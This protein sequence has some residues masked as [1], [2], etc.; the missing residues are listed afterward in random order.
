MDTDFSKHSFVL[1][2]ATGICAVWLLLRVSTGKGEKVVEEAYKVPDDD[3]ADDNVSRNTVQ[4]P[5]FPD[6]QS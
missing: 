6:D 2:I 1:Q 5:S 3:A 4:T